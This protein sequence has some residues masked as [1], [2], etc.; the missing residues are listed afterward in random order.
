MTLTLNKYQN[1]Y[2][3]KKKKNL[4]LEWLRVTV[5]ISKYSTETAR[6]N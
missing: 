4:N 2:T 1:V 3:F 5:N 6:V